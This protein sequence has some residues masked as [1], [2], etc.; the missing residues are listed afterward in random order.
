MQQLIY[1]LQKYKYFLLF[2]LLEFVAIALTINNHSFHKSKFINSANN[3]TGGLYKRAS[4]LGDYFS[5]K[6]QN[7]ELVNE[8]IS[9]KNQLEY[10]KI[11]IDCR[12]FK[13]SSDLKTLL[14]IKVILIF[15]VK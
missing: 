10:Y 2:L 13:N 5:L 7:K 12:Y 1:F 9:L 15:M 4:N 8:N 3:L 6:D 14:L 11:L